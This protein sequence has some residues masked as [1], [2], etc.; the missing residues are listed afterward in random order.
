[1]TSAESSHPSQP[2]TGGGSCPAPESGVVPPHSKESGV[3]P[4][5]SK[6]I[7]AMQGVAVPAATDPHLH[8]ALYQPCIPGNTGNI[9]RLC[10]GMGC[11]LHVIGPTL[12]DFSERRLRRAGLDYWPHLAWTLHAD[13]ESFLTWL[14]GREPWLIT[15]FA[16][17][18]I[19]QAAWCRGDVLI[20]GNEN[21]GLPE[22]WH[23]RW[24]ERGLG[25]PIYGAI[26]SYNLAN[27]AAMTVAAAV[28]RIAW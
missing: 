8:V 5:Q 13:P 1:M 15:K 10:V 3:V 11:H 9:G 19:D 22:A 14:G 27:A 16:R 28:A 6:M 17:Q 20:L 2:A 23:Q 21:H 25:I 26:R 18:R 7:T 12:F 24:P 4:P